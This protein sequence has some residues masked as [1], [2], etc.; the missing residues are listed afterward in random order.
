MNFIINLGQI[1]IMIALF[2]ESNRQDTWGPYLG[3]TYSL[4]TLKKSLC[5]L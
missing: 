5:S 1:L 3:P 4:V 2:S